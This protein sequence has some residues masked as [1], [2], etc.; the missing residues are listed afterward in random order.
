VD[1]LCMTGAAQHPANRHSLLPY[2]LLRAGVQWSCPAGNMHLRVCVRTDGRTYARTYYCSSRPDWPPRSRDTDTTVSNSPP[3]SPSTPGS[4]PDVPRTPPLAVR[5][6]PPSCV[7]MLVCTCMCVWLCL[8]VRRS[9][10]L[11]GRV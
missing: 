9:V 6:V 3:S 1:S 4:R 5:S 11:C 2:S 7:C 10:R 8:S